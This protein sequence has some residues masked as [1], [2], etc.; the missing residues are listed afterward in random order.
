[1]VCIKTSA[2][3]DFVSAACTFSMMSLYYNTFVID[4]IIKLLR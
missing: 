2:E 4:F 3:V 1:V